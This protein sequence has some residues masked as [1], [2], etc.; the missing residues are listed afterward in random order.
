MTRISSCSLLRVGV[1]WRGVIWTLAIPIEWKSVNRLN[2]LEIPTFKS[3]PD[4][5]EKNVLLVLRASE[6]HC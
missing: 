5:H 1:A 6:W 3:A 4:V 2:G